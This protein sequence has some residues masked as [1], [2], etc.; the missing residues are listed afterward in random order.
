LKKDDVQ[1]YINSG[2]EFKGLLERLYSSA[3]PKGGYP[4]AATPSPQ[5]K[6]RKNRFVDCIKGFTRFT[7]QLKSVTASG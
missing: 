7:P 5:L 3:H 4:V 6:C 2:I 1:A